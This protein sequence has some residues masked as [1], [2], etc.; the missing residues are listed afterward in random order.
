M[1]TDVPLVRPW[2]AETTVT[3]IAEH[4]IEVIGNVSTRP[5]TVTIWPVDSPWLVEAT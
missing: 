1:V 4:E 3:V 2:L 5:D